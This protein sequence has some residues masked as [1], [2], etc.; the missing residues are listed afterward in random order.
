M[1]VDGP[2]RGA[3]ECGPESQWESSPR[4]A[5]A[6]RVAVLLFPTLGAFLG[7]YLIVDLFYRPPGTVGLAVWFFQGVV[8]GTGISLILDRWTRRLLPLVALLKMSMIFPDEA[9]S[10]FA[11]ALRAGSFRRIERR[12]AEINRNGLG[13]D[14]VEASAKAIELITVLSGHDRMTRGHTERV[15]AYADI[16]GAEMGLSDV[17]RAKL[18]WGV[19][20]HDI[21]KVTVP[22]DVLNKTEPLT[23][24]E[25]A[26]MKTHPESGRK[27]LAPLAEWLGPWAR[28]AS[29]HH[30]RWD[31]GGYPLGLAGEEISLAGRITAV[32]DAY[33]VITSN[34]S[35]KKAMSVEAARREMV[36]CA[37]G[38]FDPAVVRA[39][40]NV[41]LG[42][43][44]TAGVLA[45]LSNLPLANLTSAPAVISAGIAASAATLVAVIPEPD[46]PT[47]LAFP[48]VAVVEEATT[49]TTTVIT[50]IDDAPATDTGLVLVPSSTTTSTT[51][52]TS[53]SADPS[54]SETTTTAAPTTSAPTTTTSTTAAPVKLTSSTTAPT[55]AS[56]TSTPPTT[57][58]TTATTVPTT[59]STASTTTTP[60]SA[61]DVLYL[62]N[63]G[64]GDSSS[65]I[66]KP[67]SS[68]GPDN[69]TL[70]NYN[71]E[72][73]SWPGSRFNP[74]SIG[75]SETNPDRNETFWI[76]TDP[77]TISGP[78]TLTVWLATD[79][80]ATTVQADIAACDRL[81]YPLYPCTSIASANAAVTTR[82][83][84]GFQAVTFDLGSPTYT[85]ASN[86]SLV[87]RL[88]TA[89]PDAV[90]VGFD[91]DTT[92]S[93]LETT[94]S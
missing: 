73:D 9:P 79:G 31:G 23:D 89:G 46:L 94:L 61:A 87:V 35:Y 84:A 78:T 30:E 83:D 5:L 88:V 4:L 51:M 60:P 38:H 53:T 40:L 91:A 36:D 57:L 58:S 29:E 71:T 20:L 10:R 43:R 45:T 6:V 39:F 74:T 55:T 69:A 63:P 76:P 33:D 25:W 7:L 8:V 90:H 42:K 27:L 72:Q 28:A 66:Y 56:T 81:V 82:V 22:A 52:S 2:T 26:L 13:A 17:D 68:T 15:R 19:M 49:T 62:K 24:T 11:V 59:T 86:E 12:V 47:V 64:T 21:G 1:T 75:L 65:Q 34:R 77:G 92:P 67:L 93:R 41:S 37:G 50:T 16:I 18:A 14:A 54:T 48:D 32:A 44:W 85:F 80:A 70:P 3:A